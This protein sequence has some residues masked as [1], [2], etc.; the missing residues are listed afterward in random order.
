MSGCTTTGVGGGRGDTVVG[1]G[2]CGT[3]DAATG[4][5][6]G[7]EGLVVLWY[8]VVVVVVVVVNDGDSRGCDR[9]C[10]G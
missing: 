1:E 9:G 7:R 3:T 6:R 4:A 2:V 5:A 8:S 10:G